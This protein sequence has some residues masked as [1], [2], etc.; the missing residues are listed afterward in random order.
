MANIIDTWQ[1]QLREAARPEKVKILSS[2][3]KTGKGEYGE[4]DIFIGLPVPDNR[5]I[6]KHYHSLPLDQIAVMLHDS[7]H[8]FRLAGLLALVEAYK[9]TRSYHPRCKEIATFYLAHRLCCNNWDLVDLSAP[10]I[11]GEYMI[12]I[13][14][15][16]IARQLAQSSNIWEQ[17][18]AIISTLALVRNNLFLTAME[19]AE[20]LVDSPID[21]LQKAT[22]WVLREVGKRDKLLLCH[23]LDRHADTMPRTTLRYAIERFAP[24]ERKYYMAM[25]RTT[26]PL[27]DRQ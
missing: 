11:L 15:D 22:G 14:N 4:G 12:L 8:E 25:R 6:S 20:E 24:D 5:A 27:S 17:R 16:T 1:K 10:Y 2:F 7:I 19:I 21:L 23:F 26:I 13:N 18:I 9:R 3:F